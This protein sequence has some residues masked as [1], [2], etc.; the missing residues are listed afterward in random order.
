MKKLQERGSNQ[1]STILDFAEIVQ[2]VSS[3]KKITFSPI[4]NKRRKIKTSA[5]SIKRRN[6]R[7]AEDLIFDDTYTTGKTIELMKRLLI[8]KV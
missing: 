7:K 2:A 4:K 6:F 1:A 8:E 3:K 5:L